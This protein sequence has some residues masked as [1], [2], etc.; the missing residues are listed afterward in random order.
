MPSTVPALFVSHGAP[1]MIL[2]DCPTRDFLLQLGNNVGKPKGIICVSAHWTTREPRVT[3]HPQPST[4]YDFSGFSDQLYSLQY[5]APGD[6]VLAKRV[7]SLLF[8][9]GIAGEQ[10]MSRGFDHGAWA[11]LMLMY[12]DADIPVIQLSVQPH[13][14]TEHHLAMGRALQPLLQEEI[15]ILASG[16]ATHNLRDFFGQGID[17]PP[18]SYAREFAEWLAKVIVNGHV[19]ELL[20][21]TN[22]APYALKNHPTPEHFLPLFV[23]LGTG[24][25]GRQI[26]NAY[27]YG[28]LSMAAFMWEQQALS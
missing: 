5:P 25:T 19:G 21:Y 24:G 26:H 28:A 1:S 7:L 23:A 14:G 17:S 2:D 8:S 22:C 13:M 16:S 12:P 11:P 20:D 27:T 10:D 15:L 9:Q 18:L 3:A 4:L 6:P